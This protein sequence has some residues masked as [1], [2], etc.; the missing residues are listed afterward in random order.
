[1]LL[2]DMKLYVNDKGK[3][4]VLKE[5]VETKQIFPEEFK[6]LIEKNGKFEFLGFFEHF[7]M[8]KLDKEKNMNFILLRRI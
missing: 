2:E 5:K 8:K 7:S 6:L 4:L 1:M 3:K